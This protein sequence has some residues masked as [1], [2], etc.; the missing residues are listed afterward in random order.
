VQQHFWRVLLTLH[1][2]L[3]FSN[4]ILNCQ[5]CV[6]DITVKALKDHAVL[7]EFVAINVHNVPITRETNLLSE[8]ETLTTN[9]L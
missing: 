5:L 8:N 9:Q 2:R 1:L 4:E 3:G 6:Q 7:D